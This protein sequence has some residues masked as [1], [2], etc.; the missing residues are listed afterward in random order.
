MPEAG[1]GSHDDFSQVWEDAVWTVH[2][3]NH[4]HRDPEAN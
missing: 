1:P 3:E 2:Q 4:G